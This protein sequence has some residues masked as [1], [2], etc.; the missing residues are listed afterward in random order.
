MNLTCYAWI[1]ISGRSF[2]FWVFLKF[3]SLFQKKTWVIKLKDFGK[4]KKNVFRQKSAGKIWRVWEG[5]PVVV[6]GMLLCRETN[7]IS[8]YLHG[9]KG[10]KKL[11]KWRRKC[12]CF[13]YCWSILLSIWNFFFGFRRISGKL[14]NIELFDIWITSKKSEKFKF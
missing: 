9:E 4:L 6:G 13:D 14:I 11:R 1:H 5:K 10:T 3:K 7:K 2:N 8:Q 12:V